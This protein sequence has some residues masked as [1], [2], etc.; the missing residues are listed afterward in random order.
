MTEVYYCPL[1]GDQ[2]SKDWGRQFTGQVCVSLSYVQRI[3]LEVGQ[4]VAI[5]LDDGQI[6]I[7]TVCRVPWQL[8]HGAWVVGLEG[9]S[10]GYDLDRVVGIMED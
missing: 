2:P 8:G 3:H 7:Y 4:R 1:N 6:K 9:R 5:Q 10:G